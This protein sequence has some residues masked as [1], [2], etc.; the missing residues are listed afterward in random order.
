MDYLGGKMNSKLFKKL[1][2][3]VKLNQ[4][5]NIEITESDEKIAEEKIVF[6]DSLKQ[7]Q[8]NV[9][10]ADSSLSFLDSVTK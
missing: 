8:E 6:G 9:E 7:I 4:I 3:Q 2:E 5:K 1:N 10:M